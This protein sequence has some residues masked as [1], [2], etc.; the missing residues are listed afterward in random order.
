MYADSDFVYRSFNLVRAKEMRGKRKIRHRRAY[1]YSLLKL[2]GKVIRMEEEEMR[3][4]MIKYF[5]MKGIRAVPSKG[6]ASGPDFHIDGKAVEVKGSTHDFTRMLKQLVDYARKYNA[7]ELALPFDGLTL[8]QAAQLNGLYH[9]IKTVRKI[10]LKVY[11]VA[12]KSGLIRQNSFYV[13]E[14]EEPY[15]ILT[16]MSTPTTSG[17]GLDHK[18]P[19]STLDKALE[20]LINYSPANELKAYICYNLPMDTCEV[21][22]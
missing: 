16:N 4:I 12:P 5:A 10:R 2:N 17:L 9:L 21:Q 15:G 22:I 8:L 19:D 14:F 11:V 7:V 1:C 13:K 20:N 6:Q 3:L 18:N